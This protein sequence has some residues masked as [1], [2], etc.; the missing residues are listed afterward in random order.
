[1]LDSR[2]TV[3][4]GELVVCA[5]VAVNAVGDIDDGR[6]PRAIDAGHDIWPGT[7]G[8]ALNTVIGVVVTNAALDKLGCFTVA[9][10][11]H[12]GLARAVFPPHMRSDGDAFVAASIGAVD[13]PVDQVRMLTVVATETAIRRSGR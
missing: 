11:A 2:A 6:W 12:D 5:I 7:G 10:G 8:S 13:A 9:Q 3:G 1:M 4:V